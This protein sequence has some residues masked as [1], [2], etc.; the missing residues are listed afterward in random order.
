[1]SQDVMTIGI[2]VLISAA[3]FLFTWWRVVKEGG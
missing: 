2:I 3:I 1:M